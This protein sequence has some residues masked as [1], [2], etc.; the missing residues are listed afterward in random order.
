MRIKS[1]FLRI[2]LILL[3][4]GL[5]VGYFAFSTFLFS[6]I[7]G[8]LKADIAALIPRDVDYF[9]AKANLATAFGEFPRLAVADEI[10][11][12]NAWTTFHGSDDY[13]ELDREYG[14]EQGLADLEAALAGLPIRVQPQDVFG[15]EDLAIAGYFH[16]AD[17]TQSDWAV[18]G[19]V[20]WL[21]KLAV[22]LLSYPGLL[23][24]ESQGLEVAVDDDWVGI[25]GNGIRRRIYVTR[26]LD[27]AVASTSLELVQAALA[28]AI[29]N[30][31]NSLF[32]SA[33]YFD[34]ILNAPREPERDELELFVDVRK[35]LENLH[36]DHPW[37]D[38]ASQDVGTALAGRLIQAPSWKEVV[39]VLG[40]DRGL[41]LDLHG[42]LSSE[43]IT[44]VQ[45]RIYRQRGF[46]RDAMVQDAARM[47]PEDTCL[48]A[49][50]HGPI[51]DLLQ[52]V[53]ASLEPAAR[54]NLE[55]A[56]TSTG[57]YE[58]LDDLIAELDGALKNRLALIV[59]P[60][61]FPLEM[62]ID[63]DT[64]E[65]YYS[66]PPNDGATVFAF[67]LVTWV[68]DREAIV[69]IRDLIGHNGSRFGLQG[70]NPGEP[71]YWEN[72]VGGFE[73]REFWSRFVPGTGVIATL[74][75]DEHCIIS[76]NYNMI[77]RVLKTFTQGTASYPR[78]SARA[79]FQALL[80][81]SLT[82]ANAVVWV[83]PRMA[84]D[85]LREQARRSAEDSVVIDWRTLRG[86]HTAQVMAERFPGKG[87]GELS[88]E[89][90]EEVDSAVES[91]LQRIGDRT[92]ATAV[93]ALIEEQ[94]RQVAYLEGFSA[95]LAMLKLDP[96]AFELSV[97]L[98]A[99]LD[100]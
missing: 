28:L 14:I 16:G 31:E 62:S 44:P 95:G 63:P 70:A 93:P 57:Q 60:N 84:G 81:S 72:K 5:F 43:L 88:D 77:V 11:A 15:G 91:I 33:R 97:R 20:N 71:G 99:P 59:R 76:N 47:A 56:F 19:R 21:G 3:F 12:T 48:F 69:R 85:T 39:G 68:D 66:G 37:P 46:D 27:V 42:E 29:R 54:S 87:R 4:V 2:L 86:Q 50:L 22:S 45:N 40:I 53:L 82:N 7:E 83:N 61:D 52:Q 6:P 32:Q 18:Y 78:L 25:Q 34:H 55:E 100:Q 51:G 92:R 24:L 26:V 90:I 64:G 38:P 41:S 58:K 94:R 67:A 35:L 98:V 1:R 79:D 13:A 80:N 10:E 89:E 17:M 8:A 30:G 74:N 75:T 65:E 9:A 96:K 36:L 23:Q 73:T 49:Y